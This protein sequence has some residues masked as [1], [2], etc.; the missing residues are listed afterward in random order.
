MKIFWFIPTH[1]DSRYL[2]TSKGA[3]AATFDYF[4]QVAIAADSLGYEGVLLP[5]GRS[6]ED[7]WVLAASL[8]DATRRLKFLVA[9][10]PGLVQPSQSA[11]MRTTRG[12][13]WRLQNSNARS[14]S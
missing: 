7:S 2:G 8:I 6:C 12:I 1:G 3:R 5:T 9:L 10:R 14:P 13:T 4:K 11:R